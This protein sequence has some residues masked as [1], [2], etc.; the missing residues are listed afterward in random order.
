MLAEP[1]PTIEMARRIRVTPSAVSHR[2]K[3]L[4][5]TRLLTRARD[6]RQVLYRRT[7]LGDQ[8]TR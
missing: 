4:H 8:L 6:A 7:E 3:V 1:L 2:L 5:E